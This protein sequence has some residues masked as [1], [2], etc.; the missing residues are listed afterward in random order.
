MKFETYLKETIPQT[1]DSTSF[2]F[3]RPPELDYK[4]G[5]YMLVTIKVG[6]KELLHPF[7]F[8]TSPT[9][10]DY[11]EF[12][13]KFTANEYSLGLKKLKPGAWARIDAPYGKF[14]FEGEYPKIALLTGGIGITPFRSIIKYATDMN[15]P[16]NISVF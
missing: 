2:R 10:R 15:L 9:E 5:Q 6:E 11:I 14:T 3:P 4:P 16:A 8:S 7:S 13:K 12:T 1:S